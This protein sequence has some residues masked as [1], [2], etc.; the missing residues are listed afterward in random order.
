MRA[1]LD[2]DPDGYVMPRIVFVPARGWK[3]EYPTDIAT[4]AEGPSG[5]PSLTSER[6]WREAEHSLAALVAHLRE[7]EWGGRIFGYHLERGEWFQPADQGYDRSMANCEASATG[8]ARS[9]GQPGRAARRMVRR[10]RPVPHR[11]ISPSTG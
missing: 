1:I 10:Q 2:A 11:G 5:D 6:F 4:Y 7:Y 9:Q 3:R 8:C